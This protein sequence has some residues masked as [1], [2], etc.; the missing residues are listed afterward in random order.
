MKLAT[1]FTLALVSVTTVVLAVNSAL[2]ISRQ[3]RQYDEG[4]LHDNALLARAI[5][6]ALMRNFEIGAGD[7]GARSLVR[8]VAAK[9]STI[10]VQWLPEREAG[11]LGLSEEVRREIDPK[12]EIHSAR[13]AT[14]F[15]SYAG[16]TVGGVRH[17]VLVLEEPLRFERRFAKGALW[18]AITGFV[19]T[20]VA[21]GLLA[22]LLGFYFV[23]RPMRVL[24]EFARR[25]GAG[26]FSARSQVAQR[27][28]IGTLAGELN[29]MAGHLEELNQR[30]KHEHDERV[31]TLEQLRHAERLTTVGKL[32]AGIAHE[33]GTPLAVVAGRARLILD[34]PDQS[35]RE[36]ARLILD[37]TNGIAKIIRQLMDFAR[38]RP[39][40]KAPEDMRRLAQSTIDLLRP[41]AEKRGV[42]LTVVHGEPVF[43]AVDAGQIQQALTNLVVNGIQAMAAGGTLTV[44]VERAPG[45]VP[46]EGTVASVHGYVRLSVRDQGPGIADEIRERIFEP[47]FTTKGV[48]EGTG[49]GLS[50]TYGIV[51]E[52]GGWMAVDSRVGEGA[53]FAVHLPVGGS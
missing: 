42:E 50:V 38:R 19:A 29:A 47:F 51:Q 15:R 46:P 31:V 18:Q 17:G 41:M 2:L 24:V 3:T 34:K 11:A 5:E 48:G 1:K 52:H 45:A 53:R 13:S 36:H 6:A 9:E 39:P 33:L 23:G 30:V 26:D 20:A 12:G 37:Q 28:E 21:C 22:L 32:A 10:Q 8:A 43:A 40:T 25:V 35:A 14:M 16:I 7:D 27:D 44:N 49:L 4:M